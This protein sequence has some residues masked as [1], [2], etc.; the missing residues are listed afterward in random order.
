MTAV[1]RPVDFVDDG[2]V[3][4]AAP[5]EVSV[6]RVHHAIL[7]GGGGGHECLTQHL[8]AEHLRTADVPALAAE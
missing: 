1:A 8:S 5:Q 3:E 2:R 6:Q 4:V 7:D